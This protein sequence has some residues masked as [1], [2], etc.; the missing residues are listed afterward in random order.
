MNSNLFIIFLTPALILLYV[1]WLSYLL[2]RMQ[3]SQNKIIASL[4]K[5][6]H[7]YRVNLRRPQHFNRHIKLCPFEARAVLV[8]EDAHLR[9]LGQFH[10]GEAFDWRFARDKMQVQWLGNRSL[11]SDNLHWFLLTDGERSVNLTADTGMVALKSRQATADIVRMIAPELELT[12]VATSEFAIEK[13]R[14]ALSIVVLMFALGGLA[15]LDGMLN[16]HYL[17]NDVRSSL[18]LLGA[19]LFATPAYLAMVRSTVP[20]R[21][22]MAIAVLFGM[23]VFAI[24]TPF[25]QHLDQILDKTGPQRYTYRLDKG[26]KLY[27]VPAGPPSLDFRRDSEYWDQFELGST[28]EFM[29]SHGPLGLWQVDLTPLDEKYKAFYQKK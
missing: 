14:T 29:L 24:S 15:L 1:G 7:F 12:A 5:D 21:E 17:L 6:A 19:G 13:N 2:W 28:H 4:P 22:A 10:D 8:E 25:L 18:L 16:R 23:S 27:A 3:Q 26:V 20:S 9:L 11:A